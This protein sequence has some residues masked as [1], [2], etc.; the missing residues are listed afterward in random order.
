MKIAVPITAGKVAEHFGHCEQ[1]AI[2]TVNGG[3]IGTPDYVAPPAHEPGAFPA[4]LK[5]QGAEVV[6][7][8]GMGKRA[9]ALFSQN[10]IQVISGVSSAEP[11]ELVSKYADGTLAPGENRCSH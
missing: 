2:F 3:N 9:Q 4:W 10:G 11:Q 6:I 8:G 1:F 7:T 5:K